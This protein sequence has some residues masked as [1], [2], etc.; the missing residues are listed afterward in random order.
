MIAKNIDFINIGLCFIRV[1]AK[2]AYE[3]SIHGIGTIN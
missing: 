1:V 3:A 2:G